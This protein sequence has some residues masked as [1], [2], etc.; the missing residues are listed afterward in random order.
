[1]MYP[2]MKFVFRK[3]TCSCFSPH[4]LITQFPF[5]VVR[6]AAAAAA[7]AADYPT[8]ALLLLLLAR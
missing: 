6:S 8:A 1:M 5:L 2:D 3:I 7:A 4:P